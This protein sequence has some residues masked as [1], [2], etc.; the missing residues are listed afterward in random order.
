[1]QT[2]HCVTAATKTGHDPQA[3]TRYSHRA[4]LAVTTPCHSRNRLRMRLIRGAMVRSREVALAQQPAVQPVG[5]AIHGQWL[6]PAPGVLDD[7][8]AAYVDKVLG[9]IHCAEPVDTIMRRKARE[10]NLIP[11][12]HLLDVP[13][14]RVHKPQTSAV[15]RDQDAGTFV[16]AYDHHV[17]HSEHIDGELKRRKAVHIAGGNDVGDV[18][19]RE[20]LPRRKI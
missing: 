11:R 4:P 3:L 8:R 19:M 16:V 20:H 1:M 17:P 14:P 5:Q 9:H 18:A 13:Q 2:R 10:N 6:S 7:V 15:R 12:L